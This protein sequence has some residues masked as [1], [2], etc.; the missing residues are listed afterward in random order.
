MSDSDAWNT[1]LGSARSSSSQRAAA[2]GALAQGHSASSITN[3]LAQAFLDEKRRSRR[4]SIFFRLMLL[5]I[6][7]A[8]LLLAFSSKLTALAGLGDTRHTAL[9]EISGVIASDQTANANAIVGSLESALNDRG[10]AGVIL[11]INSPG[12]SPVQSGIVFDEILRLRNEYPNT[13]IH[14]VLG[15]VCASGGY[16]IAAAADRIYADKASIVGSIGVRM[17]S[18]GLTGTLEKL[19][20]E[21]RL[22]TAGDNKAM[23]DPFLPV[24]PSHV[25]HVQGMLN[26]IHT[27]FIES[28]RRG[29]GD[30]IGD[31][32]TLFSGLI[33]SGEQ[34]VENGLVDTLANERFV[35][36]EVI[37]AKRI[38]DFTRR[39][40]VFE[41]WADRIGAELS[42]A[43]TRSLTDAGSGTLLEP[44]SAPQLR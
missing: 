27:Q 9:I 41:K 7:L 13:P 17:D 43:L 26:N 6:A 34:A 15:D 32:P 3:D 2:Q 8:L 23:L 36:R 20:A 28:V 16:Y 12:G 38:L 29:R 44:A 5:L 40:D 35:A 30:R 33:W 42:H 21:R 25:K 37:G 14:A 18:F 24:D 22:L 39:Q 1:G 31:D 10:T 11:R 4:W 19:G